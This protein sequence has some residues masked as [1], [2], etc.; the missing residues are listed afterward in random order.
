MA[1]GE[2]PILGKCSCG[3]GAELT[4]EKETRTHV[5]DTGTQTLGH[6]ASPSVIEYCDSRHQEHRCDPS[7]GSSLPIS[8]IPG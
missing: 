3:G 5:T 4:W 7:F 6:T 1:L 2:Q 8:P